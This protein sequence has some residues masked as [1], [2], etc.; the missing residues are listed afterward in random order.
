MNAVPNKESINQRKWAKGLVCPAGVEV[1][2]T[3]PYDFHPP[4]IMVTWMMLLA[5]IID[6]SRDERRDQDG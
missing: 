4:I 6:I 2:I 3:E 5:R 1:R